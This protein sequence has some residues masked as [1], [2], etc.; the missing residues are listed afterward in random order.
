MKFQCYTL[1]CKV[2]QYETQA[3]ERLLTEQGHTQVE[4]GE[5][6][7]C[8]V[9]TCTVTAVADRKNR[10]LIRRLRREHPE[11]VLAVC[12][13]YAQVSAD[14]VRAL[15]ADVIAGSGDRAAFLQLVLRA[16][17]EKERAQKV[18]L[19]DALKRRSFEHLPAGG[20]SG[21]T[22]AMLKVQD[23]CNNFCS[24][25]IIPYARG[26]VRS[27]PLED[28]VAQAKQLAADGYREIVVTGIEIASWGWDF[29]D[30]SRLTSLVEAV[31]RA[32]PGV[33]IRLGSLEPRV[34]DDDFC[35]RL[36]V[37]PNLCPQ[38]HLSLQSGSDGVLRRMRR[39]YD[40][41][42]YYESVAL[43]R[44]YF[45][46]CA[47]TTDLIVGFPDETETEFAE[48]MAFAERCGF[49]AMHIFPYSRRDGTPAAAMD[50][51][52][53]KTVKTERAARAAQTA[54]ALRERFDTALVGTVQEV[55]FEQIEDGCFTGHA[56][57]GVKVY[58]PET[59]AALH[60]VLRPVRITALRPDGVEGTLISTKNTAREGEKGAYIMEKLIDKL[61][62]AVSEAFAAAGYPAEF[63]KVTVSNRP[64][65]CEF[66][67]N[68]AMPT[69]KVAH[70]AP[71]VI[72]NEVVAA[73]NGEV[74]ASA[75][76]VAP[77]F[78]NLRVREDYL[79]QHLDAMRQSERL[80]VAGTLSGRTVVMDYG[81]PNVAK[82]LHIGHL[83]SAVI[84][85]S[86][87]RIY[88]YF[89]DCVYGD[90]HLG[91]WGLQIGLIIAELQN[92]RPDLPYFDDAFTGEYPAE[93]P[94]TISELEEIYPCA[95]GKSKVDE[96][97]ARRAHEATA[98]LQ[99]HKPG[100]YALWQQIMR[101]SV[102]DLRKN[103][104]NL[105]VNF[106]VW[107]GESDAEAYIPP[108]LERLRGQGILRES[109][110]AQVIDVAQ[111]G[112]KKELPPCI[113]V[114][115]DGAT[116]Y[117][118]TD[119]ATIVQRMEDYAP[120]KLLYL[121]DKRQSLHFEQVFRAARKGG[122]VPEN[123]ELQHIG[124]GTMNGSDGKPFKTRDGGVMRLETLIADTTRYVEEKIRDNQV[125]DAAQTHETA[126]MIAIAALKYGDLSNLA[127]KDYI[128]D[129]ERFA[130]FEGNTGP[131]LLYT[132][133]RIKSIL[134][135]YGAP[136]DNLSIAAADSKSA[137]A[138]QLV[139]SQMPDQL[140]LAYRD[141][142]PNT[143]CAYAYELAGA[144]N[145]FYHETRIL[146]EPDAAKQ[147][148]YVAL[149]ALAKRALEECI[150][151]LGFEAPEKM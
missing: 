7:L 145:Q 125:V 83:R 118:T 81:G 126:K 131:Y 29:K 92:R 62:A 79:A 30:G 132:I 26:P 143:V 110:G 148:S 48:S 97:F 134:S 139:L 91:D 53:P 68:G 138:L 34:V 113:L 8:I 103:Y 98:E 22:R 129:L 116:L 101:V 1:G 46:T 14:E 141:S 120:Q 146:A 74:F 49:A 76:A 107:K 89:G 136:V 36:S 100:Y 65:L 43:L 108:M 59:D 70:K 117:A 16:V 32:A 111:D 42:R 37:C 80:G 4:Q 151:L 144:V 54:N 86:I 28:A 15:G 102:A 45:P 105:N 140:G 63:G 13:C 112:D 18:L 127:T 72:A 2:N 114:K 10:T 67:C 47:I 64:D 23:G 20:L 11:A 88:R 6:D 27:L 123:V 142:A 33:R 51:Q 119:L 31:C 5:C 52:I 75:E 106:D 121:T 115:S 130:A 41:E 71:L 3:L 12:G 77:G 147:Q 109:D 124:F 60:N 90:I 82:P 84:G 55:L 133:V 104:D 61:S 44:R 39:K 19:D 95:S 50:G 99:A 96:D 24:Y 40:S 122:I 21:R 93:A 69:A 135:R 57:C 73:L 66:Q 56:P 58:V 128:F 149:I 38:F 17:E 94:F 85:E 9:N 137:K 25:C 87:K 35:R 78:I 150:D